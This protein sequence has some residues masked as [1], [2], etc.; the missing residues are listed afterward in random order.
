MPMNLSEYPAN[1]KNISKAVRSRNNGRCELC[2]APGGYKVIRDK[3]NSFDYPW[4]YADRH[5][6]GAPIVKII[7]TVHHID[8]NKK[9]NS[10]HNLI[11]L[12][13]KCHCRL[14]LG[15][16]IANRKEGRKN[17]NQVSLFHVQEKNDAS[18]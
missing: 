18:I 16:H 6:E 11:S 9:N 1:W 3:N 15:K 8:G 5:S 10:E 4:I 12:C 7:L 13:Q 17:K 2:F 14:D